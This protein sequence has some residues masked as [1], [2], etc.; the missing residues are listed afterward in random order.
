[1]KFVENISEDEYTK[2]VINHPFSH[3]LKSYEWG[4]ISK[5]RGLIPHYVGLKQNNTLVAPARIL[6]KSF[7]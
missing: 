3:F 6:E 5:T 4:E 1:M 2:F 7:L